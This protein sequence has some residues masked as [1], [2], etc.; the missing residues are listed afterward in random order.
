MVAVVS[1]ASH[2]PSPRTKIQRARPLLGTLVQIRTEGLEEADANA[3]ISR[4]FA[5]IA[6]VHRL[7]SFH[8]PGSDVSRL[9]RTAAA[10]PVAVDPRT[11]EVLVW[12]Q[13]VAEASAGV[14]DISLGRKLVDWGFLPQPEGAPAPDAAATWRDIILEAGQVR[15][16]RP[17]WIDL[18]G[19]AKG[20][21]VDQAL[22]AMALPPDIQCCI[23]AGGDLRAAGP[24]PESVRL[25]LPGPADMIPV[26]EI[27]NA[28]LASS[29]GKEHQREYQGL[30]VVPHVDALT[31][32][33]AGR[34]FFVSVAALQCVMA[35]AL[36]KVVLACGEK[37][38][39]LLRRFGAMAYVYGGQG[40]G[41]RDG[42]WKTFGDCV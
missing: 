42:Q 26:I 18:G 12:A 28:S 31:G 35:D 23:N 14:F 37:S 5:A 2:T 19:I 40:D 9:N 29:S 34:G 39:P 8:E 22:A 27:E 7:M 33:P 30:P 3:A 32:D 4:G 41:Q 11:Y 24:A 21:A 17:L 10:G 36:T 16:L 13:T 1:N 38:E 6:D 20:F 25:R 15:F